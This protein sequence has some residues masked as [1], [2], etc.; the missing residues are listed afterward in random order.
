[1]R[2]WLRKWGPT[3]K[4]LL[5][6]AILVAIGRRFWQDLQYPELWQRS[7]HAG[8]LILSGVLYLLGMATSA[9]FWYRLLRRFEQQPTVSNTIRAY[10]LG[11][12]GKYVPGKAWGLLLRSTLAAGPGVR[13][14]VAALTC[15]YEVLTTMTSGA[16]LGFL[17]LA[18]FGPDRAVQLD[19]DTFTRLFDQETA[20]AVIL[21]RKVLALLALVLLCPLIVPILP[22]FFNRVV[23]RM[24]E[25]F[26]DQDAPPLARVAV[27]A[28][29]E[30]LAIT[31]IPRK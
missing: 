20:K 17:L 7:F 2:D 9:W 25:R 29:A 24:V 5:A 19:W 11:H 10:Y 16:L 23:G 30:G 26:R 3:L 31:A 22:G 6:L 28:F 8:W 27:S 12:L 18:A 21:D 13:V 14:G 4:A 15:F 1:M